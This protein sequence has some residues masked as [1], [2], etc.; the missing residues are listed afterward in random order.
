MNA[1]SRYLVAIVIASNLMGC[2]LIKKFTDRNND[3]GAA[4]TGTTVVTL[5]GGGIA[6]PNPNVVA[7]DA[8]AWGDAGAAA[9]EAMAAANAAMAAAADAL[10]AGRAGAAER[11]EH[12]RRRGVNP[13]RPLL[14]RQRPTRALRWRPRVWPRRP[15]VVA[16]P[17]SP[18]A[19]EPPTSRADR[20]PPVA[21]AR[22][23]LP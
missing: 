20:A 7:Y 2:Q 8:A 21:S 14:A 19:A 12:P 11:A 16:A 17:S 4:P 13:P 3:S 10:G 9:N 18:A 1:P 23:L 22:R 5:D 6:L 15:P